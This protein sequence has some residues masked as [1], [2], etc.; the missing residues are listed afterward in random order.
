MLV[1]TNEQKEILREGGKRLG[2]LLRELG[3]MAQP[4]VTTQQLEDRARALIAELG[5]TPATLGYTPAGCGRPY[6]AALCV[7]IN[8]EIVHGIPNEEPKTLQEG[9]LVSIDCL[10]KHKGLIVDSCLTVGVGKLGE[11]RQRLLNAAKEARAE[12]L[13]VA[14]AGNTVGDIGHA[15][16]LVAEK[17]GYSVPRELGGH[18]VGQRVHEE[19]F[20]PNYG[21]PGSGERLVEGMVLAIE[22][23]LIAGKPEIKAMPD[24]YTYESWDGTDSAQFEH[25]VIITNGTPEVLTK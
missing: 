3:T 24:G 20:V 4:G 10:L 8:Q 7:S 15:V 2:A 9:D 18:G 17:Y 21:R 19:P 1:K 16:G 12:A 22:P 6:P 23:I 11:A 13:K 25:T 5:D 14:K